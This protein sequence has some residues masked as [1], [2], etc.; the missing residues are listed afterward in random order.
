MDKFENEVSLRTQQSKE[1]IEKLTSKDISTQIELSHLRTELERVQKES[2]FR[3]ISLEITTEKLKEATKHMASLDR[4]SG[5]MAIENENL[6]KFFVLNNAMLVTHKDD[7]AFIRQQI[8]EVFQDFGK[9][10]S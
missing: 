1:Q 9:A 4:E 8:D 6:R 5:R 7:P 10:V 2:K 3:E